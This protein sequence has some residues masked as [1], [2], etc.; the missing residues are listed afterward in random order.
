MAL[1]NERDALKTQLEQ[2]TSTLKTLEAEKTSLLSEE[3][4]A[5]RRNVS[6]RD[7]E[8]RSDHVEFT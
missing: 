7:E 1:S 2:T 6:R 4:E 3:T 8:V 5:L